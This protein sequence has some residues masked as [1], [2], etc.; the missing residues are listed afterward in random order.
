MVR[1]QKTVNKI[2]VA[3]KATAK[4]ADTFVLSNGEWKRQ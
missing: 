2:P 1:P 4:K 3:K